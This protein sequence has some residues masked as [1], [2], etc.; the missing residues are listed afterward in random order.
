MAQ[1]I[2]PGDDLPS[3]STDQ[4]SQ[5]IIGPGIYVN[6]INK[7]IIPINSGLL[8]H[9]AN[10]LY[11]ESNSRRYIPQQND[12]V[13]GKV[14]GSFGDVFKVSLSNFSNS[15]SLS[16]M[17][18]P[19]ATK[20]NR[21]NIK[22]GNLVYARVSNANKEIDTELEC[23]DPTTGKDGGFGLLEGGYLLEVSLSFAR[24]LLFNPQCQI[25]NELVKKCKFEIAIGCN[26]LIWIKSD[27]LKYTLALSKCLE[28]AQFL[29]Q[30]EL[31]KVF[32]STFKELG[33]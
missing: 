11:I 21:P 15:V 12:F 31:N 10:S 18:F 30:D 3:H 16:S 19:N 20:K 24:F 25:L 27:E 26:G 28:K 32:N 8:N 1:L 13:I 6:P 4:N 14:I 23:I 17:A 29:K 9:Q 5:L 2:I 22:N 33:L 7:S